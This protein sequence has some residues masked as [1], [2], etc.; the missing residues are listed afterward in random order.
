[1]FNVERF[2]EGLVH[3]SLYACCLLRDQGLDAGIVDAAALAELVRSW[4]D[5]W[6]ALW[7]N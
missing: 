3:S 4:M 7:M 6:I 5:L 1:M 2:Q